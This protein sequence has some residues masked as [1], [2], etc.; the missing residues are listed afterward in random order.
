MYKYKAKLIR[1]IDGDTY[2]L[3]IDLGF[4][5]RSIQKVRLKGIDTWEVTGPGKL[6]GI[7]AREF[8]QQCLEQAREITIQTHK[9]LQTLGRYVADIWIDEKI[10][11]DVLRANGHAADNERLG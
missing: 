5:T 2:E 8:A 4:H 7:L 11:A 1:V 9:D 3:D 6:K 10:L